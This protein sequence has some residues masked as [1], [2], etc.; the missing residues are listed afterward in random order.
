MN[1]TMIIQKN[2]NYN[3]NYEFKLNMNIDMYIN[4][5]IIINRLMITIVM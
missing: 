1:T 2:N 3:Q 5:F 4:A